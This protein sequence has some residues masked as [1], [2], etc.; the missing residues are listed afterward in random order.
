VIVG[1]QHYIETT[2]ILIMV[3]VIDYIFKKC[4]NSANDICLKEKRSKIMSKDVMAALVD[5]ELTDFAATLQELLTR[6]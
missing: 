5:L 4:H 6:Q 3:V 1:R 2:L